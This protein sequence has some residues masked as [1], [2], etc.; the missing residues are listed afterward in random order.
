M[1]SGNYQYVALQRLY[2]EFERAWHVGRRHK[3]LTAEYILAVRAS[4]ELLAIV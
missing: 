4:Q 2:E 3:L 1:E